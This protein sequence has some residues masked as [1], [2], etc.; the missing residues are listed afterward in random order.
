LKRD[1]R[2]ESALF[3]RA[4]DLMTSP[5]IAVAAEAPVREV[6][7]VML[8]RSVEAV[9]VL[10]HTGAAIGMVSD[11]DLMRRRPDEGARAWWLSLLADGFRSAL[12]RKSAAC[13]M[14]R[15]LE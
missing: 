9:P 6:A 15:S 14:G 7:R 11:G 13:G 12:V 5:A 8:D 3:L 10:D 4:G 1:R 2:S